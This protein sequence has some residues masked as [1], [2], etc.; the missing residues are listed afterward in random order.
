MS[1]QDVLEIA[2]EDEPFFQESGGGVTL[3]GGEPLFQK[4]FTLAF[5][6]SLKEKGIH[7]ALDTCAFVPQKTLEESI[8]FTDMYL[9]DFKCFDSELHKK[10][11]GQYNELIKENLKFLSAKNTRLEIRIPFIPG[12]NDSAENM[13][14]TGKFLSSLQIEAVKLLPYHSYACSKYTA[15]QMEDTLPAVE[16]PEESVIKTA[17]EILQS[18]GLNICS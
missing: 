14:E 1:V 5:L 15:L 10:L 17:S 11:T 18:Y 4:E 16:S 12:C 7:T 2:L 6:K 3:S 8:S 13:H 9:V